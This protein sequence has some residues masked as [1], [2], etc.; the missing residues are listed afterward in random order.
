MPEPTTTI[1]GSFIK[2]LNSL[3]DAKY[4]LDDDLVARLQK[5]DRLLSE[6]LS[7]YSHAAIDKQ[8]KDDDNGQEKKEKRKKNR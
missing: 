6:L 8:T 4:P 3:D 1:V 5:I 7:D 2:F